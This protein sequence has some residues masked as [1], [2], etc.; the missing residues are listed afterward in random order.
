M[1]SVHATPEEAI[2]M[3]IDIKA[4]KTIGH[5]LGELLETYARAFF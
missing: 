4:K 1:R 3:A 2:K 5:A